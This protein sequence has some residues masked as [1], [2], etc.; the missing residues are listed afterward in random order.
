MREPHISR[1]AALFGLLALCGLV[2]CGDDDTDPP[3]TTDTSDISDATDTSDSDDAPTVDDTDDTPPTP[4]PD[5]ADTDPPEV[6]IDIPEEPDEPI[7]M[8]DSD[9]DGVP[10]A[11]DNCPD[12]PNPDQ[13]DWDGDGV[14]DACDPNPGNELDGSWVGTWAVNDLPLTG[15]VTF[16]LEQAGPHAQGDAVFTG[17]SC[18][19][20][21]T[22]VAELVRRDDGDVD[23]S[24]RLPFPEF[25][26]DHDPPDGCDE[27]A[28]FFAGVFTVD[29]TMEA[30]YQ[31]RCLPPPCT[32]RDGTVEATR[33]SP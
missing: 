7:D 20:S 17:V 5:D 21:G 24:A 9:G 16:E 15:T 28:L 32:G 3:T 10:D 29:G 27:F 12:V 18:V 2:A 4:L 25:E 14:G 26:D 19:S 23:F 22:L 30:D 33:I 11:I 13:A 1:L 6:E 8:T 31:G